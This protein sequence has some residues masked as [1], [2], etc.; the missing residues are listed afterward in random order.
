M[1]IRVYIFIRVNC[2]WRSHIVRE[3]LLY[4]LRIILALME[5]L[6]YIALPIKDIFWN[7]NILTKSK[8]FYTHFYCLILF[9]NLQYININKAIL[10]QSQKQYLGLSSLAFTRLYSRHIF[11]FDGK[12]P[13]THYFSYQNSPEKSW[14]EK[15]DCGLL[16]T[17]DCEPEPKRNPQIYVVGRS[18]FNSH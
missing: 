13:P 3:I 12:Y 9:K 16:L 7:E 6:M 1:N 11:H 8:L 18:N 4:V 2:F 15:M 17:L 5:V 14:S 10:I